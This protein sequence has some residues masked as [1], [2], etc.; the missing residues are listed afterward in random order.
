MSSNNATA[1][2]R[3]AIANTSAEYLAKTLLTRNPGPESE[4]S[5]FLDPQS[6][7]SLA[8]AEWSD[9]NDSAI[10]APAVG[11]VSNIPGLLGIVEL[12]KLNPQAPCEMV[13]GHKKGIPFVSPVV[14]P[15]SLPQEMKVVNFT[16]LLC[17]PG[18]NGLIV[19][20]FFPGG[21]IPPSTME[22]SEATAAVKTVA[23]A[24]RLGFAYGKVAGK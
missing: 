1:T 15:A 4:G 22:P 11:Y 12:S 21:A 17:G 20:T 6:V 8:T 7:E 18:D 16:T 19:W 13:Q 14:S 10:S 24:I 5:T 2:V 23:D 3:N 9:A